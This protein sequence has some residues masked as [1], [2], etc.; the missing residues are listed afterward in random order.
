MR[1]ILAA[2]ATLGLASLAALVPASGAQAASANCESAW[3][4]TPAGH[5]RAYDN[6]DCTGL[7]GSDA[8]ND[9]NWAD[10]T[11]RFQGTAN[12]KATSVVHKGTSG[13]AVKVYQHPH[14][15]GGHTCLA[16]SG[17][18][19]ETLSGHY[20]TNGVSVNNSISSHEW[21][22]HGNCDKFLDS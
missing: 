9:S 1:R 7:L 4:S 22:W 12:D 17:S 13:I 3:K 15:S 14:Y 6:S 5:F 2:A 11:G 10:S 21:V 20:Y 16:K 19:S 8:G 18:Y